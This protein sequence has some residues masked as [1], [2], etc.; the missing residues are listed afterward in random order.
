[1]TDPTPPLLPPAKPHPV[2]VAL[3][4]LSEVAA[5]L[6][7][8]SRP[9]RF[10]ELGTVVAVAQTVQQLRPAGLAGVEDMGLHPYEENIVINGG[11]VMMANPRRRGV[12]IG[13]FHD[14][15]DL[16]TQLLMMAQSFLEKYADIEKL[17]AQPTKSRLDEVTELAELF[18]LRMKLALDSPDPVPEE[19]TTRINH[20]LK[21]IGEPPHEPEPDTDLSSD[22]VRRRPPDGP[23]RP[24]GGGLGEPVAERAGG[25]D[26]AR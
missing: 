1:M 15:A 5:E 16:N 10:A 2:D 13:G 23:G 12:R 9:S 6:L 25:D 19:I 21:R 26:G 20:L 11:P 14:A 24:D 8:G 17:K 7:A 3:A 22:D 4:A 18:G